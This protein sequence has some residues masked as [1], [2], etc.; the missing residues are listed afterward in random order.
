MLVQYTKFFINGGLL[1]LVAWALQFFIYKSISGHIEHAYALASCLT[2]LPLVV[3]N[4]LI[5]RAI[6]FKASGV[7]I[8]FFVANMSIMVAVT[9]L[10]EGCKFLLSSHLG[11]AWG[12]RLGF[13][14]AALIGS[15][16]SFLIKRY[17]VFGVVKSA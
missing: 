15:I 13:L 11:E 4:F 2:Y 10:A 7:F 16:P 3:V 6:I 8:R 1:G 9:I 17:W 14:I 5:Q 12:D